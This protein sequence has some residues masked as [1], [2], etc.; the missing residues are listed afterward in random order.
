M[1]H[2]DS[3]RRAGARLASAAVAAATMAALAALTS[4]PGSPAAATGPGG[5]LH[6]D[7]GVCLRYDTLTLVEA[8]ADGDGFTDDDE[9]S[10][11]TDPDDPTSH[12]ADLDVLDLV[13]PIGFEP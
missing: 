5:P 7:G 8:D 10:A 2:L 12:P 13:L 4:L 1:Y 3:H 9:R 11:G 6:C